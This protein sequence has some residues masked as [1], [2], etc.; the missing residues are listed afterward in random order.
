MISEATLKKAAG[1]HKVLIDSN[2]IIYLTDSIQPYASLAQS[3]FK[4]VES[5]DAQAIISIL[6]ISEVMQGPIRK[7]HHNVALEVRDYLENF[8][9]SHCQEITFD[10]LERV[11][12]DDRIDWKGLRTMDSLII[13]SGLVNHVDLFISNDRHFK[14]SLPQDLLL[15]FDI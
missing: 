13:A 12:N 7:G 14:D 15:S 4:Q 2:I 3:L 11:G 8:P 9:N 1:G 6:S 5:G 10:V